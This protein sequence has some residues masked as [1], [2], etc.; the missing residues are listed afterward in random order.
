MHSIRELGDTSSILH[1]T[2]LFSVSPINSIWWK[3][4]VVGILQSSPIRAE[5]AEK[6]GTDHFDE[7]GLTDGWVLPSDNK[8]F[9]YSKHVLCSNA[10][11]FYL[12]Q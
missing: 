5:R 12:I 11:D 6:A 4:I 7:R 9:N 1:A 8:A 2:K 3:H 10:V